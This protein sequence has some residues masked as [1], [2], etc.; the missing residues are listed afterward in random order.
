MLVGRLNTQ[1]GPSPDTL[2]GIQ[3]MARGAC[4]PAWQACFSQVLLG[5]MHIIN[6]PNEHIQEFAVEALREMTSS[7]TDLFLP[8]LDLVLPVLLN[9]SQ[10]ARQVTDNS[11]ARMC[12]YVSNQHGLLDFG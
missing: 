10:S 11:R 9:L 8:Q 6:N 3:D 1:E 7:Q 2:I 5:L 12:V 4:E